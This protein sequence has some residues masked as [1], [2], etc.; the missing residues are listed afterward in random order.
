MASPISLY[1]KGGEINTLPA[2]SDS[3]MEAH[4][5][6]PSL[7]YGFTSTFMDE[8]PVNKR[9]WTKKTNL[10]FLHHDFTENWFIRNTLFLTDLQNWQK[11][12]IAK[13]L[14]EHIAQAFICESGLFVL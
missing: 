7:T 14:K 3:E 2:A 10:F 6:K 13:C 11:G 5:G 9:Y 4:L 8:R 12:A 1:E